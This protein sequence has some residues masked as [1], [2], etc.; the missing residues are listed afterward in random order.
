MWDKP[1]HYFEYM[2]C[3][4]TICADCFFNPDVVVPGHISFSCTQCA[5][6]TF[7]WDIEKECP[8]C[9]I[10]YEAS[11]TTAAD[12]WI[13]IHEPFFDTDE[14]VRDISPMLV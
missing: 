9:F 10:N 12:H 7:D 14:G 11:L 6:E 1:C 4:H 13:D 8:L 2:L 5:N 3:E